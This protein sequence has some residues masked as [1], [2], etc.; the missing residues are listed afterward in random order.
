[1]K[2]KTNE[3]KNELWNVFRKTKRGSKD[4]SVTVYQP[5]FII[6]ILHNFFFALFLYPFQCCLPLL[7]TIF[8]SSSEEKKKGIGKLRRWNWSFSKGREGKNPEKL[9]SKKKLKGKNSKMEKNGFQ[10]EKKITNH[11]RWAKLMHWFFRFNAKI[12]KNKL[13]QCKNKNY[14]SKSQTDW[15]ECASNGST[16]NSIGEIEDFLHNQEFQNQNSRILIKYEQQNH[17]FKIDAGN[18]SHHLPSMP[19]LHAYIMHRIFDIVF[20]SNP[21][22]QKSE[23][24]IKMMGNGKV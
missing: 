6:T 12:K 22:E 8:I 2:K 7:K 17:K 11:Q 1:M 16:L 18:E 4:F 23:T 24:F 20:F 13:Q 9:F 3:I 5:L 15:M 10:N 14:F 19:W 21:S